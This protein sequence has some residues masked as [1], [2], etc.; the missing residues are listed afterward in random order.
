MVIE[1][2][3]P[4]AGRIPLVANPIRMSASPVTYEAAPPLLGEHTETVLASLL[5][6][7][8]QDI[9]VLIEHSIVGILRGCP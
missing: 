6:L 9:D 2:E 7:S 4:V 3:H 8:A 1:V 5:G